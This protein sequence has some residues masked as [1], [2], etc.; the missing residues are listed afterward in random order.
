MRNSRISQRNYVSDAKGTRSAVLDRLDQVERAMAVLHKELSLL[1]EEVVRLESE[2]QTLREAPKFDT[3]RSSDIREQ[4]EIRRAELLPLAELAEL[5][6][7]RKGTVYKGSAGTACLGRGIVKQGS[8]VYYPREL[9]E[10]H[11][12]NC[13]LQGS[14]GTCDR[15]LKE[16][17]RAD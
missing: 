11:L 5:L 2:N 16:R 4:R 8:R 14:C 1:R 12:R 13:G 10:I 6:Q 7:L 9:V 3:H 17:L 15:E